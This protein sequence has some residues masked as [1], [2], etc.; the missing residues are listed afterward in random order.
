MRVAF[1]DRVFAHAER[2]GLLDRVTHPPDAKVVVHPPEGGPPRVVV[3]GDP[4]VI[5]DG[6]RA[7]LLA[8][9]EG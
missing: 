7:Y 5:L 8:V 1:V 4:V 9:A 6:G 3:P 2:V